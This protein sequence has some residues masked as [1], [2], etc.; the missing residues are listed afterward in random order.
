VQLAQG[1]VRDYGFVHLA[2]SVAFLPS[3]FAVYFLLG[4]D[5]Q[6]GDVPLAVA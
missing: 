3:F 5:V 4:G 2:T 6:R 1:S